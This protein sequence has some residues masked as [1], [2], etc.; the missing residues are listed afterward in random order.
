VVAGRG[1]SHEPTGFDVC[2][3]SHRRRR[4]DPAPL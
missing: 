1:V 3:H 4:P 2:R